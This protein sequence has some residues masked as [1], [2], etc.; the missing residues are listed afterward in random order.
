MTKRIF[1][2]V[3]ND[4]S[5]DQR[6]IRICSSLAAADYQV[7]LVG[8]KMKGSIPL[9]Q[10]P[11][12]QKRLT[13]FFGKG[14][15]FYA[16]YQVRLLFFLLFKKMDSICAIDLDT[17]LPCYFISVLK[18]IPRVFDAHE[19][20]CE[21]KEVVSRPFIYKAWR[22]IERFAVPKF[23]NGYTVSTLIANELKKKYGVE[24]EVIRSVSLL[25]PFHLTPQN[26]KYVLY[27]GAV[28]E[29]RSFETLIPAMRLVNARLIICG[30]GNFLQQ[31]RELA[32]KYGLNDKIIFKG[33][34]APSEL[35]EFTKSAYIGVTLFENKGKSNYYSL[36]NRFFDYLHAGLPQICVD[37]PAYKEINNLCKVAVLVKSL[38]PESLAEAMNELLNNDDLYRELQQNCLKARALYNWQQEEKKLLAFYQSIIPVL[39]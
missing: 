24:Y 5:Y 3:T 21:M 15:L 39:G 29:G 30:D 34:L 14:K 28:N 22:R 1:F 2:T 36:A 27:Q 18:K 11:F 25:R 9:T 31:A 12:A 20:F 17:I 7:T 23:K 10:A 35:N 38:Q 37:Y 33:K 4:L 16:E 32:S 19:L 13:C 26:E 6:M 8:R